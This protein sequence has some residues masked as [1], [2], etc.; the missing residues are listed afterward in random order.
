MSPFRSHPFRLTV[1]LLLSAAGIARAQYEPFA[2][3]PAEEGSRRQR[4]EVYGS[5][6]YWHA[7]D[8]KF[9]SV[10]VPDLEGGFVT[11]DIDLEYDDTAVFGLGVGWAINDHFG[12]RLEFDYAEADYEAR[13]QDS[14]LR[15]EM[16]MS[17]GRLNL[18]Y[19]LLAGPI[20]PFATLGI[21]YHYFD[22]GIPEGPPDYYCWWDSWWGY[23]CTGYVET[24]S[25]LNFA[26]NAGAGLRWDI[27][28]ALFLKAQALMTWVNMGRGAGWPHQLQVTAA[29]GAKF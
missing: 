19:N 10:T 2:L 25:E 26:A 20:T 8:V 16:L 15:G 7:E 9:G 24:Y 5:L 21:G 1:L 6:G 28:D 23:V 14:L 27:N 18:D 29:F 12:V 11:A 3:R 4:V 17:N 13:W 22:T